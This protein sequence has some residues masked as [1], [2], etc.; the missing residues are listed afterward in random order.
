MSLEVVGSKD[1]EYTSAPGVHPEISEDST[2]SSI[3][4]SICVLPSKVEGQ[5]DEGENVFSEI[6][7]TPS[8]V[9]NVNSEEQKLV[10]QNLVAI[11]GNSLINFTPDNGIVNNLQVVTGNNCN[12]NGTIYLLVS[13][14]DSSPPVLHPIQQSQQEVSTTIPQT[15]PHTPPMAHHK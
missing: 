1:E 12:G 2:S 8:M 15:M 7:I 13:S 4:P 11:D 10:P 3:S 14:N 5:R 9:E 6:S